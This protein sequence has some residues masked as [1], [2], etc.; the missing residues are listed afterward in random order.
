MTSP[1][2][3]YAVTMTLVKRVLQPGVVDERGNDVYVEQNVDVPNCVFQ[4]GGSSENLAF[5]DQTNST[6]NVY[7]P[8]GT[9]VMYLDAI[10]YNGVK[11]EVVGV[12]LHWR[13]PFSGRVSP[14]RVDV[15][16]VTGVTA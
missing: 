5:A 9:D 15:N 8:E 16:R 2:F 7:L 4:P 14:I 11:Y 6:D 10:I 1:I 3:P 13:S 12:P